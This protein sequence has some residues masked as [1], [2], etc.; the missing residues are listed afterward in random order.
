MMGCEVRH[1]DRV[2]CAFGG[3]DVFKVGRGLYWG[4]ALSFFFFA[5]MMNSLFRMFLMTEREHL[6]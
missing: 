6:T 3:T 2:R 1:E 5:V 4:S